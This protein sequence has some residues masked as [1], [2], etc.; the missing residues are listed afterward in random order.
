MFV[1]CVYVSCSAFTRKTLFV[2]ELFVAESALWVFVGSCKRCGKGVCHLLLV[3]PQTPTASTDKEKKR[4]QDF[5]LKMSPGSSLTSH[6]MCY[7]CVAITLI[8]LLCALVE[9][10]VCLPVAWYWNYPSAHPN[11]NIF[12]ALWVVLLNAETMALVLHACSR[13]QSDLQHQCYATGALAT[14][15]AMYAGW[16]G[17]GMYLL[18]GNVGG[19]LVALAAAFVVIGGLLLITALLAISTACAGARAPPKVESARAPV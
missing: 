17:Y 5:F 15:S 11:L 7:G 6:V 4:K 8:A 10:A 14:V 19:A 18:V 13:L 1:V 16:I 2:F 12:C 3:S 9:L